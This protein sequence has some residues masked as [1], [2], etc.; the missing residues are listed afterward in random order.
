MKR[1][2]SLILLLI[3]VSLVARAEVTVLSADSASEIHAEPDREFP[4][5]TLPWIDPGTRMLKRAWTQVP[6]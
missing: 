5:E 6:N 2:V 1:A 3:V 4:C